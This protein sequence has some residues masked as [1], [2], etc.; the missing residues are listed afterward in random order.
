[1]I[2]FAERVRRRRITTIN[3]TGVTMSSVTGRQS[4]YSATS[5]AVVVEKEASKTT[6]GRTLRN[7]AFTMGR[8]LFADHFTIVC[9]ERHAPAVISPNAL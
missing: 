6:A 7:R 5:L 4:R 3:A 9:P 8:F 1:M 2:P